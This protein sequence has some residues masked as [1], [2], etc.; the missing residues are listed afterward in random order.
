MLLEGFTTP[1]LPYNYVEQDLIDY[2]EKTYLN[3][4]N[5]F[6]YPLVLLG[7]DF[8]KLKYETLKM[9]LD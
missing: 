9:S 1:L 4:L 6:T 8:N 3:I 2:I 5:K 7:G